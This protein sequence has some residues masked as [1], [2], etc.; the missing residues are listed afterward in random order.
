MSKTLTAAETLSDMEVEHHVLT[1]EIGKLKKMLLT[2][3]EG[4]QIGFDKAA[5]VLG[6][7]ETE[8]IA[9]LYDLLG[10]LIKAVKYLGSEEKL[11]NYLKINHSI[12]YECNATPTFNKNNKKFLKFKDAYNSYFLDPPTTPT[13]ATSKILSSISANAKEYKEIGRAHV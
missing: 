13:E 1:G 9:K 4:K 10:G 5:R 6:S 11:Q 3:F 7:G 8:E 12:T 2:G